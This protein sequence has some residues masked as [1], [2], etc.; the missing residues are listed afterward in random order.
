MSVKTIIPAFPNAKREPKELKALK[1]NISE[2]FSKT[3]Q[4]EGVSSGTPST[5][6]RLK[7]CTLNCVWC[8]TTEVWR[9]GNPYLISEILDLMEKNGVVEDL[10]KGH[11]LIFTGGSPLKQQEGLAALCA[12]FQV[13]FHFL[14]FIEVE[15][16][17][18]LIPEY[19][20]GQFV[21]QWNNSPKLENS[22]MRKELRYKPEIIKQIS[23]IENSWFKFVIS[24]KDDWREIEN[25]FIN[26]GL[27]HPRQIILMPCGSSQEE[28]NKNRETVVNLAVENSVL[29]SDRLHVTIWDKKVSV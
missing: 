22:G 17:C 14:P 13:R 27:I 18:M 16:E 10:K 20:F 3:I 28:L 19:S 29:F 6:I 7:D 1:I 25:D 15:N 8:D 24:N 26:P 23:T 21:S 12:L 2:W 4:G 5:F 11:H 9:K